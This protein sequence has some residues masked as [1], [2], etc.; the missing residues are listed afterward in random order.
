MGRKG[1]QPGTAYLHVN[2][3]TQDASMHPS[4]S[5]SSLWTGSLV[6]AGSHDRELARWMG[7]EKVSLH[8]SYNVLIFE[9]PAFTD[10]CSDPIGL[11]W[12][13]TETSATSVH[14]TSSEP[15]RQIFRGSPTSWID[16][17]RWTT[18]CGDQNRQKWLVETHWQAFAFSMKN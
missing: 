5:K 6:W 8:A 14:F 13:V 17:L 15:Q 1:L 11:N 9:F 2:L 7:R 3:K 16:S 4:P 12:Q 18:H 10:E